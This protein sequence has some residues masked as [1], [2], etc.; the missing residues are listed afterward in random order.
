MITIDNTLLRATIALRGAEMQSLKDCVTQQEYFWTGDATYWSGHAPLLFPI[1]GSLW[2]G[3]F[4][5]D[6]TSY[7]VPKHGFVRERTW[8]V[9]RQTATSVTLMLE[10]TPE[11]LKIFPWPYRLEVTYSLEGRTLRADLSVH[12]LSSS[13]TMWFQM[14]GHP[15]TLLPD[16]QAQGQRV[17]GYLRFEGRPISMLRASV[18]GCTEAERVPIPW[19][20]DVE[21]STALARHQPANALVPIEVA[22]FEKEA[23]IFDK[24]QVQAIQ[25]LDLQ[26]RRLMRVASSAPAW[27]VWSPQGQHAPF[28]C[29]EPWYG[30]PDQ[31]G[32]EGEVHERPHIQ[33]AAPGEI[34]KG[35][36]SIEV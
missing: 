11:E 22:T 4:R 25:V 9:L 36:Y 13:S 35:W 7:R 29:C 15:S 3:E 5:L 34:W 19:N 24:G 30:L 6:G 17:Q 26:K 12:N 27:L 10:G 32:F 31:Q 21:T 1:V 2:N 14:G 18:Q 8:R 20:D 23:L 28:L 16:W 33:H